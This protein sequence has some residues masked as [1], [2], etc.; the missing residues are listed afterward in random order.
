MLDAPFS[1]W[2]TDGEGVSAWIEIKFKSAVQVSTI[3]YRGRS[4][5]GERNKK[6][7]IFFSGGQK[8]S[9]NLR[10]TDSI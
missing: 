7:T 5:A 9:T 4:S 3:K 10:N 1:M 6:I 8:F 2:A